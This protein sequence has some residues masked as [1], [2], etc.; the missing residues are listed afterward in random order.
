MPRSLVKC[1]RCGYTT[2]RLDSYKDHLL[3]KKGCQPILSNI[4][5]T[6]ENF[7][8]ESD[9]PLVSVQNGNHNITINV[10]APVF[11]GD[12]SHVTR[13]QWVSVAQKLTS[14]RELEGVQEMMRL[15]SS[16][17]VEAPLSECAVAVD[18]APRVVEVKSLQAMP[19]LLGMDLPPEYS[20]NRCYVYLIA[21]GYHAASRRLVI[22][23]GKTEDLLQ[24]CF[25][26]HKRTFPHS[27]VL[28]AVD[29]GAFSPTPVESTLKAATRPRRVRVH[30]EDKSIG[31]S[32]ECFS[33]FPEE[34][35]REVNRLLLT[36]F[37]QHSAI[38]QGMVHSGDITPGEVVSRAIDGCRMRHAKLS[39]TLA[40]LELK[41]AEDQLKSLG[42]EDEL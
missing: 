4:K 9:T 17:R 40:A 25:E 29:L 21:L 5:P 41:A 2:D 24:R 34:L 26:T 30:G 13:E 1:I 19:T 22:K 16:P 10:N 33:A 31:S 23:L 32:T 18:D 14:G 12:I 42:G 39:A 36:L 28:V 11:I 27:K 8:R 3:R 6:L 35:S 37:E 15:L 20:K 7:S 38:I